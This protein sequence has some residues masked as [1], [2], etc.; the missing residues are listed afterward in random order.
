MPISCINDLQGPS[1]VRFLTPEMHAEER[2]V[3]EAGTKNIS[4][5]LKQ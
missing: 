4:W 2:P 3:I 5:P 1:A